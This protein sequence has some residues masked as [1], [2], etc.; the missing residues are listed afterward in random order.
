MN[1]KCNYAD[2]V[3]I[4]NVSQ[5][6]CMIRIFGYICAAN[7]INY[8]FCVLVDGSNGGDG[9]GG[10]GKR[11]KWQT[12]TINKYKLK[13]KEINKKKRECIAQYNDNQR[14]W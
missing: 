1:T 2:K 12:D 6:W 7:G 8:I 11:Q 10:D 4:E 9:G 13:T 14:K 3:A 5:G